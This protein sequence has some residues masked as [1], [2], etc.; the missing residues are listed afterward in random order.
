[1]S[2]FPTPVQGRAQAHGS[3]TIYHSRPQRAII[4]MHDGAE[5][6]ANHSPDDG[7]D[8]ADDT[9]KQSPPLILIVDDEESLRDMLTRFLTRSGYRVL[10]AGDGLK[11]LELCQQ[12]AGKISVVLLDMTM[13]RMDGETCATLLR[14]DHPGVS[15][16]MMSAYTNQGTLD[17]SRTL[18]NAYLS[19]PFQLSELRQLIQQFVQ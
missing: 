19:K 3:G 10:T 9:S 15:I 2:H 16:I 7:D 12:H 5:G 13:P 4:T 14:Q 11:A 17:R 8:E 6:Y 1:M 18:R